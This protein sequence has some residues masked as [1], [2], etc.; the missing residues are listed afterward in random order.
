MISVMKVISAF[1][2][3]CRENWG[4]LRRWILGGAI[5][6]ENGDFSHETEFHRTQTGR[7]VV[8][9]INENRDQ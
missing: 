9:M 5:C 7:K 1:F 3:G 8:Q 2:F 4:V 6:G